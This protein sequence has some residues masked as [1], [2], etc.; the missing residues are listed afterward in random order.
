MAPGQLP[1]SRYPLLHTRSLE[2]ARLLY[3]QAMSP[4]GVELTDCRAGFECRLHLVSIGPLTLYTGWYGSGIKVWSEESSDEIFTASFPLTTGG[5]GVHA[6][7]AVSLVAGRTG[8]LTSPGGRSSGQLASDYQDVEVA[9][10]RPVMD[11]ALAAL[12][13]DTAR[14]PLR[15]EAQI[16]TT[17][18]AGASL[19]RLVRFLVDELD[20]DES[21]LASPLVVA[22]LTDAFVY[23]LLQGQPHNHT[24]ALRPSPRPAEPRHVRAAAEYL[25]AHAA[26]PISITELAAVTGVSVWTLQAGFRRHRGCSP[27]EFLRERRLALARTRLLSSPASTTV[28]EIA[29]ACGFEHL[30]RFSARYRAR[31]GEGPAETQCRARRARWMEGAVTLSG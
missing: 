13:G 8:I 30:G 22:R 18:G 5:E 11:A 6:G 25:D 3:S 9:I 27:M 21:L 16:S 10:R 1:L 19:L 17:S 7:A 26:D 2:E 31:F 20:R 24:A 12:T 15:F 29:L 28:A 4:I 23:G 14:A